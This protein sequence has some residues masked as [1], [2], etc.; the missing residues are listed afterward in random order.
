MRL[1]SG[2]YNFHMPMAEHYTLIAL[3]IGEGKQSWHETHELAAG[4][5]EAAQAHICLLES[6]QLRRNGHYFVAIEQAER[7]VDY[8]RPNRHLKG[9]VD[10]LV[11]KA[12]ACYDIGTH[13]LIVQAA[14]DIAI[15]SAIAAGRAFDIGHEARLLRSR[16]AERLEEHDEL[17]V[18]A[19]VAAM[20]NEFPDLFLPTRTTVTSI[21]AASSDQ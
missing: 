14:E 8:W 2:E 10:A 13:R 15:A 18:L 4:L 6:R 11:S 16:C 17:Q 7:A 19:R 3:G 21:V 9:M 20:K 12:H 5:N 1:V